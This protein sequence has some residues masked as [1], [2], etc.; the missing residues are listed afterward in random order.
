MHCRCKD[1]HISENPLK[2]VI[3][4]KHNHSVKTAATLKYCDIN[5][6]VRDKFEQLF[7]KGY[8]LAAAWRLTPV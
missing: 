2:V 3:R 4:G 8:S 1:K 7:S 5:A 6:S